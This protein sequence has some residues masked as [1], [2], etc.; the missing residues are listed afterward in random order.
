[1]LTLESKGFAHLKRKSHLALT[2]FLQ[3][4]ACS[5]AA[6]GGSHISWADI[7]FITTHLTVRPVHP[8]TRPPRDSSFI[9]RG[10]SI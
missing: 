6:S 7:S 9:V 2:Q 8:S 1:M 4:S 5:Q 3:S 10:D